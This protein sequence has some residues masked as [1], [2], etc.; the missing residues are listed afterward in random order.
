MS[1]SDRARQASETVVLASVIGIV[2]VDAVV[3]VF[4]AWSAVTYG[5][6][7]FTATPTRIGYCDESYT[8]LDEA[9][10]TWQEIVRAD[11]IAHSAPLLDPTIG[12]LPIGAPLP[13]GFPLGE[14]YNG[15][16]PLVLLHVD[17]GY[18]RY[19]KLGGP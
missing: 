15:C 4:L 17:G 3:V 12:T 5:V 11:P 6:V 9:P 7:G 14:G 18:L 1:V 19:Y 8:L 13:S 2:L 16:G 10:R